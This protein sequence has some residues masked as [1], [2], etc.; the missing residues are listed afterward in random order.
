M[1]NATGYLGTNP[2]DWVWLMELKT[3]GTAMQLTE[4]KTASDN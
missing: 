1:Q 2:A 4:Y 3:Q